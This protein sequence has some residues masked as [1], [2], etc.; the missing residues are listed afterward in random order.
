MNIEYARSVR[1]WAA[2]MPVVGVI[3][4][5]EIGMKKALFLKLNMVLPK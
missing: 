2:P 4:F 5:P 1:S 3:L